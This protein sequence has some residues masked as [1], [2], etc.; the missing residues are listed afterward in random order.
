MA[1][2]Q[3]PF[4][5]ALA[6]VVIGGGAFIASRMIGGNGSVS[7][8]ANV[9]VTTADTAGFRGYVIGSP[10]A[11]VEVTE[12]GDFQC[13]VCASW[14]AM[15]FADIKGRLIDAGKIR[16]RFRDYPIDGAHAHTRVGSHA[17]ACANDQQHFWDVMPAIFARQEEWGGVG[18]IT[19]ST[20]R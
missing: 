13:P 12:Y 3:R 17:M 10:T 14:E 8:P 4:Y 19:T 5:I 11:P 1:P 15:Q 20:L 18:V 16:F 7:I 6:V 2:N 9:H